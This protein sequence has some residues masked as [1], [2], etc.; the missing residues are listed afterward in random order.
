MLWLNVFL[1]VCI[2][3]FKQEGKLFQEHLF[4]ISSVIVSE[5]SNYS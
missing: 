5:Y 2:V 4:A 3:L 1:S